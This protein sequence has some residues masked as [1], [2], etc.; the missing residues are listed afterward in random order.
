MWNPPRAIPAGLGMSAEP[1]AAIEVRRV[2]V[3]EGL[4]RNRKR[5]VG[6]LDDEVVVGA[7]QAETNAPP[8]NLR[9]HQSEAA[10]KVETIDVVSEVSLRGPDA[11]R[12]HVEGA[13][14]SIAKLVRHS[15]DCRATTLAV[16]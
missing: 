3:V 11:V 14:G 16:K 4:H 8:S 15:I 2:P 7:H 6:D 1:V 10:E 12:E 5:S 9:A 13:G